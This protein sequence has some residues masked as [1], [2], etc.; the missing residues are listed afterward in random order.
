MKERLVIKL[1]EEA[2][3]A[4]LVKAGKNSNAEVEANVEP[5]GTTLVV[6][7]GSV[8]SYVSILSTGEDLGECDIYLCKEEV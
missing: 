3:E 1:S 2:T 6:E 8:F 4:Y 5:S 7:I